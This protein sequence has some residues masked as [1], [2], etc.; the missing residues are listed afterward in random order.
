MTGSNQRTSGSRSYYAGI[1]VALVTSL[2]TVWTTVIRDDGSGGGFFMLIMA[3]GVGAFS[4]RFQP[5]GMA[6]A[7]LGVAV[8]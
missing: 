5:A 6:R 1:A 2:L 3:A 7:M 4:A 8:R